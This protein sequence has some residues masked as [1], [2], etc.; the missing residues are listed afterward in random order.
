MNPEL[1][2]P[3]PMQ[4][5]EDIGGLGLDELRDLPFA[6]QCGMDTSVFE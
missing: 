5:A 1:E 4:W 6:V 3:E 2:T